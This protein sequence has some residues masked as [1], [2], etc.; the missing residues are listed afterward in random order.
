MSLS[1]LADQEIVRRETTFLQNRMEPHASKHAHMILA[2]FPATAGVNAE[3]LTAALLPLATQA[4]VEPT[5]GSKALDSLARYIPTEAI[6]LYVAACSVLTALKDKVPPTSAVCVYWSFVILT[7]LLFL[8]I[9]VG[10][11]RTAGMSALPAVPQ[12][13]WW[14]LIASTVAFAVWALAVPGSPYLQGEVGGV[15][16]GFF[17][18]FVSTFLTLL[19]PIFE[20]K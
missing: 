15:L 14:K 3:S 17:A 7:P 19:E 16:A 5:N 1:S 9:F 12:W 6:T 11:R 4:P 8:I 13:P 10:K 2:K 20:S 18:L